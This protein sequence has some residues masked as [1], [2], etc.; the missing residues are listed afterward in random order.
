LNLATPQRKTLQ[1]SSNQLIEL[2]FL[3]K[4]QRKKEKKQFR[5]MVVFIIF[6]FPMIDF[7][8]EFIHSIHICLYLIYFLFQY[9]N[10]MTWWQNAF[11]SFDPIISMN[12][13]IVV[14]VRLVFFLMIQKNTQ[15]TKY[16]K[17]QVFE[18]F[19]ICVHFFH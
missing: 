3:F 12:F 7:I 8:V 16:R 4:E 13:C 9:K 18:S 2:N 17:V 15:N 10:K 5:I 6:S 1:T 14:Y 19:F 11:L